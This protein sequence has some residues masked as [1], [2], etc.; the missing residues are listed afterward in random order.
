MASL[1]LALVLLFCFVL[2]LSIWRAAS[3]IKKTVACQMQAD[4]I[5]DWGMHLT[6]KATQIQRNNEFLHSTP[7]DTITHHQLRQKFM[8]NLH[9]E[10]SM[11]HQVPLIT[12]PI[13]H[14][15]WPVR[16]K[17]ACCKVPH[18]SPSSLQL[19]ARTSTA[20]CPALAHFDLKD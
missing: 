14:R 5:L 19:Y 10:S 15:S 13:Q 1:Y 2:L 20:N 6:V 4:C 17:S 9:T 16:V 18:A 8:N 11:Y 7:P 3:N 12:K